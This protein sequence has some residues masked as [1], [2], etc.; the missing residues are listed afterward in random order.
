MGNRMCKK[1]YILGAGAS[2]ACGI[3]QTNELLM[4]GYYLFEHLQK[5][6]TELNKLDDDPSQIISEIITEISRPYI[7]ETEIKEKL[8]EMGKGKYFDYNYLIDG[9]L[10]KT[11]SLLND[12]KEVFDFIICFFN[13]KKG[14]TCLPAIDDVLGILDIAIQ[15]RS[16]LGNYDS[17]KLKHIRNN[18]F[19]LLRDVF[20]KCWIG[21]D[22]N[23][24]YG[25]LRH[26]QS[27]SQN[28]YNIFAQKIKNNDTIISFNYD[29]LL[30]LEILSNIGYFNY[31]IKFDETAGP[32]NDKTTYPY[33]RDDGVLL[34]KLHGSLNW[35]YCPTCQTIEKYDNVG[36]PDAK[37]M[38]DKSPMETLIVPPILQN[39]YN[40]IY[41]NKI[42]K[43]AL[44][45]IR[46][47]DEIIFIGY[48]LP[49]YDL[50]VKYLLKKALTMNSSKK[51]LVVV[52][53]EEADKDT[54]EI[55]NR[56]KRLFGDIEYLPIGFKRY[57]T[58]KMD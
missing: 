33:M 57:V 34:L 44:H 37:C 48:S 9:D 12:F 24:N 20:E 16:S 54:S 39:Q 58:E 49:D 10:D 26:S 11:Q 35:Y 25:D 15:E 6:I 19:I 22:G 18:L 50:H 40:N 2:R 7:S 55:E 46:K 3:S 5:I 51:R 56:Y 30:D 1:V 13:W 21:D 53:K 43:V 29:Y 4:N 45:E 17:E 31:A 36:T 52:D 41:L 38:L 47:A 32:Q 27:Y 14:S 23:L 42:W 28:A 8:E